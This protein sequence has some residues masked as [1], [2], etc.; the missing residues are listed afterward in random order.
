MKPMIRWKSGGLALLALLT[1]ASAC[2]AYEVYIG[3]FINQEQL[4]DRSTWSFVA[5]HCDGYFNHP[6]ALRHLTLA[7]QQQIAGNLKHKEVILESNNHRGLSAWASTPVAPNRVP[8]SI[9]AAGFVPHGALIAASGIPTL[10]WQNLARQYQNAG[11]RDCYVMTGISLG[12]KGE[13]WKDPRNDQTRALL[14]DPLTAGCGPDQPVNLYVGDAKWRQSTIDQIAWTHAHG[15][16]FMYLI[17][18]NSS[19]ADFLKNAQ[20][21]VLD[22]ESHGAFPDIYAVE[23]YRTGYDMTPE[24]VKDDKGNLTPAN[25]VTGIAYWLIKHRDE[26]AAAKPVSKP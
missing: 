11:F 12:K 21:T 18:P 4:I 25:T 10:E 9:A 17:S 8:N 2:P 13:G 1:F 14:T 6:D 22:L 3:G 23:Y 24:T 16:K 20:A 7:Q 19:G 15:K 26:T 5:D